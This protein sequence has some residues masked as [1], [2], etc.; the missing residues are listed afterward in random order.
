MRFKSFIKKLIPGYRMLDVFNAEAKR[1]AESIDSL[2]EQIRDLNDK[3]EYL[4]WLSQH[5][6]AE[7]DSDTKKRVFL[8]MPKATGRLREVQLAE[9]FLLKRLKKVCD[10]NHL[11][12]ALDAGTL[13]GAVRH[14]G[15]IPWDDD[16]DVLMFREDAMKL[17]DLLKEDDFLSIGLYYRRS[18]DHIIKIKYKQTDTIFIDI[19]C[20]DRIDCDPSN[21]E[22]RWR[23]TQEAAHRYEAAV[24]KE[25]EPSFAAFKPN[26]IPTLIPC[27][28]EAANRLYDEIIKE[29]PFYGHGD[30]VC[31]SIYNGFAFRHGIYGIEDCCP[32][33]KDALEFEGEKYDV[34]PDYLGRLQF[35]YGDIWTIPARINP[36]HFFEIEDGLDRDIALLKK[37]GVI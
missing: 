9:S 24:I 8:N 3:N 4:F 37:S 25:L 32:F 14:H 28:D 23:L 21:R 34:F 6:E 27:I 13:L 30:Y 17:F 16:I 20:L 33:L 1:M 15:F 12:F 7:R 31:E 18:G 22:E 11:S 5:N 10:D 2:K 36:H 26:G 29:L 35:M 19:F